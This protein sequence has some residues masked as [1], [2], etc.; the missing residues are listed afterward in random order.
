[1]PL[2]KAFNPDGFQLFTYL[3]LQRRI[4]TPDGKVN[5]PFKQRGSRVIADLDAQAQLCIG[6]NDNAKIVAF[7]HRALP[8]MPL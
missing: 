4:T 7:W 3:S 5:K 6:E 2:A 1:M 8:Q